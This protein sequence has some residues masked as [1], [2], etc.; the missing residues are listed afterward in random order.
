MH[1][2]RAVP[3]LFDVTIDRQDGLCGAVELIQ[4]WLSLFGFCIGYRKESICLF[5]H[6]EKFFQ[7]DFLFNL[8]KSLI[9]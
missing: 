3:R 5:L 9:Q 2:C 7:L 6:G 1:Y 8:K 4:G